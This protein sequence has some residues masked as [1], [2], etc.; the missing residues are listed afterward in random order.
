MLSGTLSKGALSETAIAGLLL[1]AS[2][3]SAFDS[4]LPRVPPITKVPTER[5]LGSASGEVALPSLW[6]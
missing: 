5:I 1:L 4:L 2:D 3:F 6:E